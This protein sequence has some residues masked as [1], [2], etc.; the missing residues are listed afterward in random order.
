MIFLRETPMRRQTYQVAKL[1][2]FYQ[3][4]GAEPFHKDVLEIEERQF[5]DGKFQRHFDG[6]GKLSA[7]MAL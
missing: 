2:S 7:R 6:A 1:Y 4:I 3:G 5:G